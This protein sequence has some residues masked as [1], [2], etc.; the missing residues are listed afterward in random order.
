M[1]GNYSDHVKNTS[2]TGL[3][4]PLRKRSSRRMWWKTFES[5][6]AWFSNRNPG[7][8]TIC[9]FGVWLVYALYLGN[10]YPA[11]LDA[12]ASYTGRGPIQV[13]LTGTSRANVSEIMNKLEAIEA[14]SILSVDLDGLRGKISS[15]P[16]ISGAVVER[17]YPNRLLVKVLEHK[18]Y[19][20][21]QVYGNLH[22]IDQEGSI[23]TDVIDKNTRDLPLVV[24]EGANERAEEAIDLM[25]VLSDVYPSLNTAVLVAKRR[26]NLLTYSGVTIKLPAIEPEKAV[27][28][29]SGLQSSKRL[30]DRDILAI[31][32]RV[33]CRMFVQLSKKGAM[34]RRRSSGFKHDGPQA[35]FPRSPIRK[36]SFLSASLTL[37]GTTHLPNLVSEHVSGNGITPV[38]N[39]VPKPVF[40]T[41]IIDEQIV[42]V[43][44]NKEMT[45]A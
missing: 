37:G 26:W 4:M 19:A 21:W 40:G 43:I 33:P 14:K 25:K 11:I 6:S 13:E 38:P 41:N 20:L 17:R 31:D 22:V 16:W 28:R 45:T 1:F 35:F 7:P 10:H 44:Y 32:M 3:H 23:I 9:F 2:G 8:I 5:L 12:V 36:A 24:G 30:L 39:L 42:N 18:P 27:N 34:A 15:I 29:L